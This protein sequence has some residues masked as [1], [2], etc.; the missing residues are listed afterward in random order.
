R[1]P[2]VRFDLVLADENL[3]LVEH[4]IALA[5]RVGWL[6]ESSLIAHRLCDLPYVLC[7]SPDYLR[8]RGRP[9]TPEDLERHDCLRYP[10]PGQGGRWRFR[11][12]DG[13]IASVPVAGRVLARNRDALL[14]CALGGMGVLLLPRAVLGPELASGALLDLLPAW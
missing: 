5:V 7:A 1:H 8:R 6:A 11:R 10:I 2:A 4:R 14:Q 12:G 9:R 13:P 3:D